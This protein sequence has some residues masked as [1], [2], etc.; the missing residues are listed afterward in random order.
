MADQ[1]PQE[2]QDYGDGDVGSQGGDRDG[3]DGIAEFAQQEDD[4][5]DDDG[6]K[7]GLRQLLA[8]HVGEEEG[9]HGADE[10]IHSGEK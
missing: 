6:G 9:V 7:D 5:A 10:G 3:D 1:I 2:Q 4:A 8:H